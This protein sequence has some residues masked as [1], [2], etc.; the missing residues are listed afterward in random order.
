MMK[1]TVIDILIYLFEH[2]VDEEIELDVDRDRLKS[3]LYEA[4]FEGGQ[5]ARAFDWLQEL[6]ANRDN[7]NDYAATCANLDANIYQRGRT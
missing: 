4:G 1:Q 2:Y 5:V 7:A 6:A 3:E